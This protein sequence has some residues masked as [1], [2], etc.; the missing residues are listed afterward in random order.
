MRVELRSTEQIIPVYFVLQSV[1]VSSMENLNDQPVA[2]G[3]IRGSRNAHR[4]AAFIAA[5]DALRTAARDV[6]AVLVTYHPDA[7]F[8][9]RLREISRQVDA[10]I[11]VDNGSTDLEQQRLRGLAEDPAVELIFNIENLGVARG[12]NIG[13]QRAIALGYRWAL[14]LDLKIQETFPE[15]NRLAVIGVFREEF[16]IDRVDFEYCLRAKARGYCVIRTRKPLMSHTIGTPTAHRL[17]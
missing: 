14:L 15:R 17:L 2:T 12:L 3:A 8:S 4:Q 10:V 16:F 9:A 1:A 7:E 11:I 13:V 6:C 5:L